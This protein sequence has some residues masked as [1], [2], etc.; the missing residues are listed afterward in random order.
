MSGQSNIKYLIDNN[1][2][3]W[4]DYPYRIYREKMAKGEMPELTRMNLLPKLPLTESSPNSTASYQKFTASCG[5][6]GRPETAAPWTNCSGW[7]MIG[8]RTRT[9]IRHCQFLESGIFIRMALP[10]EASVSHLP[11]YVPVQRKKRQTFPA[12]VPEIGRYF[13]GC[14]F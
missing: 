12:A 7:L 4:D 8:Q 3:I 6:A 14:A 9:R 1:I 2:H 5:D 10:N 13:P 11:Q